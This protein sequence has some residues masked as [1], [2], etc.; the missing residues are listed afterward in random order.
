MACGEASRAE[1]G[2]LFPAKGRCM[3]SSS[4]NFHTQVRGS[5]Y[6]WLKKGKDRLPHF[7]KHKS[8]NIMLLAGL[9]DSVTLEGQPIF[10]HL[11]QSLEVEWNVDDDFL[12]LIGQTEPLW[13]FTIV[14]TDANSDFNWLHDRQPVILSTHEALTTWLDTTSQSWNS[15]LSEIVKPYH[16]TC[17][18]LEWCV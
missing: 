8:G 17:S 15:K 16:D 6:E 5:Y 13:T 3:L 12:N 7:T 18:P 4:S 1:N 14:T 9:Y 11:F 10:I 2:V